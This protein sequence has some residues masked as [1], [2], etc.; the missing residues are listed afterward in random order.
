M[1][2]IIVIVADCHMSAGRLED[3]LIQYKRSKEFGV[4]RA[5]VHIRNV[6]R[7]TSGF[8]CFE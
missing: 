5:A 2:V 4:E 1:S 6:N 7:F 8:T 3:A